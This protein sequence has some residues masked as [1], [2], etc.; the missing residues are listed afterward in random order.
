MNNNWILINVK[1][2]I[3]SFSYTLR[4]YKTIVNGQTIDNLKIK[5]EIIIIK[6][7]EV[8]NHKKQWL[9]DY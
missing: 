6:P 9:N 7:P 4:R 8:S 2:H 3:Y 5:K 1:K